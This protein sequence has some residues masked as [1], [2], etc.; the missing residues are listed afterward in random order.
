MRFRWLPFLAT[1]L[2]AAIGIALGQWQLHRAAA[3]DAIATRI[4]TRAA[5]EPISLDAPVRDAQ[6]FEFR[7][8]RLRGEFQPK[9]TVYLDNRP[10]HGIAGFEVLT[11]LKFAGSNRHIL[12]DRG[13]VARDPADRTRLPRIDTPSGTVE[14]EGIAR[15][16]ASHLLQLGRAATVTPGAIVQNI[17]PE[18]FARASGLPTEPLVIDQTGASSDGLARDWSMAQDMGGD[19]HRA[20]AFQ[21]YALAATAIIFFLVTGRKRASKPK[22]NPDGSET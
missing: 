15:L 4:A 1:A 18:E 10:H 22:R 5:A 19:R 14:I 3:K 17:E 9:W 16:H 6:A 8:V 2:V 20:Y 12:V 11:P 7:R 21:W 13:W